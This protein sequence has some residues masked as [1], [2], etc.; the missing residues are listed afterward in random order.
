MKTAFL[1]GGGGGG[2]GQCNGHSNITYGFDIYI[3]TKI[4][5]VPSR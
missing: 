3:V 5:P 4:P 2:G 1:M